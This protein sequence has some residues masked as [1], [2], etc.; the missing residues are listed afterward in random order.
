MDGVDVPGVIPADMLVAYA[1]AAAECHKVMRHFADRQNSDST[2]RAREAVAVVTAMANAGNL[3]DDM[4][5][6]VRASQ[7]PPHAPGD[8]NGR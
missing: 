3:L 7:T 6:R 1:S 8:D 4:V 5:R 2:L